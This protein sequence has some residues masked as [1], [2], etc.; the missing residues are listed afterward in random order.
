MNR[1]TMVSRRLAPVHFSLAA[2]LLLAACQQ[3]IPNSVESLQAEQPPHPTVSYTSDR[4]RFAPV[5]IT[6]TDFSGTDRPLVKSLLNVQSEMRYGNYVWN[7]HGV[8]PGKPWILVDLAAQTIS[9]FR[10]GDEIGRAVTLFGVDG[11][12][13]PTGQFTILARDEHHVSSVYDAPMPYT[14]RLTGDGISIHASDV[15]AG[16]GTHGCV[17][18]PLEFGSKLFNAMRV[19]DKVLIIANAARG[20]GTAEASKAT[21]EG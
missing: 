17:G 14:L 13:T 15:R 20:S 5:P 19:G 12:P 4:M 16:V 3:D 21:S 7:D 1:F 11:H 8:R 2:L 9:V 10:D 6:P 18:V